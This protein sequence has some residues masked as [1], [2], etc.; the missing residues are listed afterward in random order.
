MGT[1]AEAA[2]TDTV[3]P[4]GKGSAEAIPVREEAFFFLLNSDRLFGFLH[5]PLGAPRGALVLCHA[6]AEEKLWSHRVYVN[7]ARELAR[8]GYAVLRFD[9]RGEGDSDWEFSQATVSSRVED[10]LR[11]IEELRA[12]SGIGAVVLVGHRLGGSVALQ[13]AIKAANKVSA[14]ALWDP[15]SSGREYF[16]QLLRSNLTTQLAV[17]GAVKRDREALV[18]AIEAGETIVADGY[19]LTGELYREMAALELT[20]P[21]GFGLPMLMLEIA[22]GAQSTPSPALAEIAG[23]HCRVVTEQPFWRET[24]QFH[25]RAPNLTAATLQWLQDGAP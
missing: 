19:E 8:A 23:A 10:T 25:Q 18:A 3:D 1:D 16:L 17:E 13:A 4:V 6:F 12:R 14:V 22:K 7:F 15:I 20:P 11:A 24:R 5:A 2:M 21:P 9:C